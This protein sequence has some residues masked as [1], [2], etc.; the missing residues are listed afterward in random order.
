MTA[1][2]QNA[3]LPPGAADQG[4][5]LR[6]LVLAQRL[7]TLIGPG[8]TGKSRLA[9]EVAHSV[10]EHAAWPLPASEPFETFD[11]IAF[12]PL[13]TCSVIRND[14]SGGVRQNRR[15]D[16]WVADGFDHDLTPK[17]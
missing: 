13:A 4:L 7:V 1:A 10:R 16:R 5:R 14:G 6:H 11:L 17:K 8:G 15:D 9:V 3:D 2:R 12:V